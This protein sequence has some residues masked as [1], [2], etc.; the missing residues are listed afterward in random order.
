VISRG[1][2]RTKAGDEVRKF[3]CKRCGRVFN[4]RT[5][6]AYEHIHAPQ[7]EFDICANALCEG[8]GI[9]AAARV[10]GISK[11]TVQKWSAKC[12]GQCGGVAAA[13]ED[14]LASRNIQFDEMTATLKKNPPR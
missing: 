13:L 10:L 4:S 14:D 3:E 1:T 9:R 2:Y 8:M 5:G 11:D 7:R 12:A 6:T